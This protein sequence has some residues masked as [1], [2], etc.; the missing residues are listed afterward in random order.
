MGRPWG[1]GRFNSEL[2]E[3]GP[4]LQGAFTELH[5]TDVQDPPQYEAPVCIGVATGRSVAA[6]RPVRHPSQLA[7][8]R[9]WGAPAA[10]CAAGSTTTVA[11]STRTGYW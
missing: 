10:Y 3:A 4:T 6:L 8:A 5:M 11:S 7:P 9:A 1:R 2:L